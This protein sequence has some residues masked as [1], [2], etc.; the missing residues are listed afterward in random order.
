MKNYIYTFVYE[1]LFMIP[2]VQWTLHFLISEVPSVQITLPNYQANVGSSIT[3]GCSVVANPA[4]YQVYWRKTSG[5]QTTNIEVVN[6]GGKYSGS[7]VNSP[8]LTI[9]NAAISD[10][11]TYVCFA[12]NSIGTGQSTSTSLDVV[13]SKCHYL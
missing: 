8:S 1:E 4:H 9:T 10:D 11:A 6:S 7:T 12:T 5:G 2:F 3:L 13:G